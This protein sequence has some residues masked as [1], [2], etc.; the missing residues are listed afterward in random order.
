M[1]RINEHY[2]KLQDSY[3][4]ANIAKRVNAFQKEHPQKEIVRMGIG[5]V[6]RALPSVCI[7]AFHKAIDEMSRDS[8][9]RGY[10]PEQGKLRS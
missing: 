10:G 9:F 5:D 4:F 6:P 1:I 7:E 2:L 8:T 3:L